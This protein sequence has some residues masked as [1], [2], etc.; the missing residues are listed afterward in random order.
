MSAATTRPEPVTPLN[1]QE[2]RSVAALLAYA[3][4]CQ[5]VNEAVV[6]SV[7]AA[8]F[9]V[10]DVDQLPAASYDAVIAFLVD[11]QIDLMMN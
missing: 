2:R 4:H 1:A 5:D 7:V 9:N 11:M 3:A 6:R 10:A 8:R